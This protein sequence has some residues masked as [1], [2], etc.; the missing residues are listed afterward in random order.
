MA[1]AELSELEDYLGR[2]LSDTERR[3]GVLALE[4]AT[5][6]IKTYTAQN[7]EAGTATETFRMSDRFILKQF[8]VTAITAV[9][10]DG[11]VK[12]AASYIFDQSGVLRWSDWQW[13]WA[14]ASDWRG[15]I[16]T[17]V[18][19]YGYDEIPP[20]IRAACLSMASRGVGDTNAGRVL[21]ERIGTY[22]VKYDNEGEVGGVGLTAAER[23][24]LAPY[25]NFAAA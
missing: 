4:L 11:V 21:E 7:I 3:Q 6:V 1:F 17:V 10:V 18:Y 23:R 2:S 8:P 12:D 16:V 14:Y 15:A 5:A 19:D 22:A 13:P 20:D 24:L 9:D 25:T